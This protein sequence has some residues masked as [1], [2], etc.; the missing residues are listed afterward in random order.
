MEGSGQ[1]HAPAA[2]P[3]G[4][5]PP[6]THWKGGSVGPRSDLDAVVKRKSLC[7]WRESNHG[8]PKALDVAFCLSICFT[9][10]MKS[11]ACSV[12][13]DL[14]VAFHLPPD[15]AD[16]FSISAHFDGRAAGFAPCCNS[17]VL[18]YWHYYSHFFSNI[19]ITFVFLSFCC[20]SSPHPFSCRCPKFGS[21][22][23]HR[24]IYFCFFRVLFYHF[25]SVIYI[26]TQNCR[27]LFSRVLISLYVPGR[28]LQKVC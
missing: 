10:W 21:I 11:L 3:L 1:F 13:K 24:H 26:L 12:Y 2:L 5:E 19:F 4:N 16:I 6:V 17:S 18:F 20:L 9:F 28:M 7:P 23:K 22:Q 27:S 15:V 25:L 14:N 8:L